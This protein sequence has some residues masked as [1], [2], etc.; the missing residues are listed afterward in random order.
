MS[1]SNTQF[2]SSVVSQGSS[3]VQKSVSVNL[4]EES[5]PDAIKRIADE[6]RDFIL[7]EDVPVTSSTQPGSRTSPFFSAQHSSF[8]TPASTEY[9]PPSDDPPPAYYSAENIFNGLR[10][11]HQPQAGQS[12]SSD[13]MACYDGDEACSEETAVVANAKYNRS[14]VQVLA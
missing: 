6:D 10:N 1:E 9:A 5:I 4:N 7:G 12:M 3:T 14:M 2:T 11:N 13:P 8:P